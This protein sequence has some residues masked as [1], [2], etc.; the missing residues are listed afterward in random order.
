VFR[1]FSRYWV[2]AAGISVMVETAL[3]VLSV[4]VAYL[5]RAWVYYGHP[6]DVASTYHVSFL[7]LRVAVF[8]VTILLA[9]YAT[10]LYDFHEHIPARQ[11]F[12]RLGRSLALAG[13]ILLA[14]YY[15][16][17]PALTTGR[18][19]FA[20]AIALS[21]ILLASWRLLLSSLLKISAISDRILIIGTDECAIDL[22]RE[23]IY[24]RHL[25]YNILGFLGDDPKLLGRSLINPR[26]LGSTWEVNELAK[27]YKA[28]RIVVAQRD[29]RGKLDM[30]QLLECK[31]S[32]ILVEQATDFYERLT[33]K[34]M[35]EGLTRSWLIFSRGFVVS[36]SVLEVKLLSDSLVAT[37]GLVLALPLMLLAAIAIRLDSP[38]PIL[39]RQERVGKD[40][41]LFT[42]WKFRSM[43]VDSEAD[44]APRWATEDDPRVT[45]VGRLLRKL[46]IDELPQL[47]NVL[48]GDMS[49]VGPRPEREPFVRRL[50]KMSP[51]YAQRHV[52][53]PGLTGWAQIRAPYAAS[54]ED[55]L[56]KLKYDLYYVKNLSFWLDASI[57]ISTIRIVLFGRGGR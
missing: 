36:R 53:R 21:A 45:R 49:L 11:L 42:L 13:I 40:G 55:S 3:V 14:I 20:A 56:E 57:V 43:Q 16:T 22:A 31:T 52:L 10:G 9:L 44:G 30:N 5:L 26:V 33:G 17:F 6:E 1:L 34:I 8:A 19:V 29:R 35:L 37:A 25:G 27:R 15:V 32:G 18:G 24:R 46:R 28:T 38:G 39:F 50:S 4:W 12:I 54:Y 51:F 47:W 41:K 7:W 2:G 48:V 23:V